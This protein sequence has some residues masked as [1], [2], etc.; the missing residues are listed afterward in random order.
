MTRHA[1]NGFMNEYQAIRAAAS[2]N[3]LHLDIAL[4]SNPLLYKLPEET[5]QEDE[6]LLT[7]YDLAL[8]RNEEH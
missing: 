2:L 5:L 1:M 3:V 6:T 7:L 4:D 8:T